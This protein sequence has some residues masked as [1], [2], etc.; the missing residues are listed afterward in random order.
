MPSK[1]VATPR[2]AILGGAD[3]MVVER[4]ILLFRTAV[5]R[6]RLCTTK[7]SGR[8]LNRASP[9]SRS[10]RMQRVRLNRSAWAETSPAD[11]LTSLTGVILFDGA[12]KFCRRVVKRL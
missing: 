3:H 12:C 2:I 1:R 6:R 5:L 10:H 9:P 8:S 7:L 4:P 11:E